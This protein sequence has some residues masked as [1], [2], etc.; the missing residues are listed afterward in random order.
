MRIV[1]HVL[2]LERL[3][4]LEVNTLEATAALVARGHEVHVL[5]GAP[6]SGGAAPGTRAEFQAAGAILH[7]PFPFSSTVLA[8]PLRVPGFLPAARLVARLRPDVVW[9]QRTEHVLWGQ[10]VARV[11]GVP[12]VSHVHHLVNYGRALPYLTRGVARFIAVSEFVRDRWVEVGI[13]SSRVDV[14]PNAVPAASYPPGGPAELEAARAA[15][16]L[17]AGVP[18]ALYY[19]R[20]AREKGLEVALDAWELLAPARDAAHLVLAGDFGPGDDPFRARVDRAVATGT[21]TALPSQRDVVPLLHAADVVLFPTLM[22]ESFGRVA[23]EAIMTHRPV[24]ASAIGAVPEVLSGRLDRSL[25]PPDDPAAL[26]EGLRSLLPW[27]QEEPGLGAQCGAE[28]E[29]RFSFDAYIARLET[30]LGAAAVA[31]RRRSAAAG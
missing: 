4:G 28:A 7:G 19:G 15:L 26:A 29:R 5:Y 12:L 27:R 9:L 23:L 22:Q 17:P 16:G 14:V 10:T 8:A 20:M 18:T 24:L 11:A 31:R 30:S 13:D 1:T 2:S 3:G 25:V 6:R 21:V